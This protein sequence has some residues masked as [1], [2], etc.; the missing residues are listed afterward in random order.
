MDIEVYLK[1]GLKMEKWSGVLA[2]V[3]KEP[4]LVLLH[5]DGGETIYT[6]AQVKKVMLAS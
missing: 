1:D 2:I 5:A 6:I 4:E 3:R